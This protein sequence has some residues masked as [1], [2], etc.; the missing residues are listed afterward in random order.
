MSCVFFAKAGNPTFEGSGWLDRACGGGFLGWRL[1]QGNQTRLGREGWQDGGRG[2]PTGLC[3]P[4]SSRGR[5]R[6]HS[7]PIEKPMM[8]PV[9]ELKHKDPQVSGELGREVTGRGGR[10][11]GEVFLP[12]PGWRSE[13]LAMAGRTQALG[14]PSLCFFSH[15][16]TFSAKAIFFRAKAGPATRTHGQVP[17]YTPE[18]GGAP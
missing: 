6:V 3:L 5:Q 14:P 11:A 10:K 18:R 17:V 9:K 15:H 13:L 2:S 4:Q 8:P 12:L 16:D 1:P 7:K